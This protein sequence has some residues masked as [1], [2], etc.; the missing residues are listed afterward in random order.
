M[1]QNIL[2]TISDTH[3]ATISINRPDRSNPLDADTLNELIDA[4]LKCGNDENVRAIILTGEGKNFS[5]GGNIAN[6]K[7]RIE[8]G[9]GIPLDTV[10]NGSRLI[11]TMRNCPKPIVA[12]VNGAAAGAGSSLAFASDF[13]VMSEKSKLAGS[14][15]MM[16]FPGDTC[17]WYLMSRLVGMAKTTEFYMLGKRIDGKEA[18]ELGLT[19]RLCEPDKLDET[20][21]ALAAELAALPTKA[22][23]YQKRM[24]TQIQY[25]DLPVL[26]EL[27]ASY[28]RDCSYTDD[29]KEAVNAFLEKRKPVFQGK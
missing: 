6:F 18:Q 4:F 17:G 2:M 23:A 26:A 16:G 1:Y 11:I 25:P 15:V 24:V 5:A 12:K 28:M 9:E 8:K 14:F 20:A 27:E 13:R 19:T 21:M 7:A 10:R 29:H 22:L 3:V